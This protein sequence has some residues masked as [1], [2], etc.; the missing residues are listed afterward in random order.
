MADRPLAE[1]PSAD[2]FDYGFLADVASGG[3]RLTPEQGLALLTRAPL[4]TLGRTADARCRSLHGDV[5]RTYIIDRNINY[6]TVCNAKCTFCA[7]RRDG[8]EHDAY[9]LE[10]EQIYE[11]IAQLVAIGGTV[12]GI[13][14]AIVAAVIWGGA[15]IVEWAIAHWDSLLAAWRSISLATRLIREQSRSGQLGASVR[16]LAHQGQDMIQRRRLRGWRP[17]L[18][19]GDAHRLSPPEGYRGAPAPPGHEGRRSRPRAGRR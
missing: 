4:H 18:D 6:T 11:K 5:L 1:A 10:P 19:Q 12:A 15:L 17:G 3:V 7:F 9:T 13:S 14:L 16:G 8:D 2:P